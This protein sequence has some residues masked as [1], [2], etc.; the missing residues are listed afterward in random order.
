MDVLKDWLGLAALAIS[1]GTFLWSRL[2]SDGKKALDELAAHKGNTT[3]ALGELDSRLDLHG[4]RLQ[5]IEGE[6]RHL[7]D[8][9]GVNE[10]KV[11]ITELRGAVGKIDAAFSAMQQTMQPAVRRIEDFLLKSAK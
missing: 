8:K 5:T 9:D 11:A 3:R 2:T 6:L 7:P 10:L 1:V 4:E